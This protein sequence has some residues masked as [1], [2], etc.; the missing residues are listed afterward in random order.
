MDGTDLQPAR[1]VYPSLLINPFSIPNSQLVDHCQSGALLTCTELVRCNGWDHSCP[2]SPGPVTCPPCLHCQHRGLG[3]SPCPVL[4]LAA[5]VM[6][7]E[8]MQPFKHVRRANQLSGDG[9]HVASTRS[10][11]PCLYY[12]WTVSEVVV[13]KVQAGAGILAEVQPSWGCFIP[14]TWWSSGSWTRMGI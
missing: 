14:H 6:E 9:L 2:Y 8:R 3:L 13:F 12:K 4:G 11:S 1:C 5:E 7:R 10:S